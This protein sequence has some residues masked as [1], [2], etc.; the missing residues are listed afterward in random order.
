MFK[1][2]TEKSLTVS[3]EFI[4]NKCDEVFVTNSDLR[5]HVSA[6][7][8]VFKCKICEEKF[9]ICF[10]LEQHLKVHNKEKP[11]KCKKCGK[12]FHL[13]WRLRKHLQIH[14][15]DKIRYCHYPV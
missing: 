4:C 1:S 14:N 13:E 8:E 10:Q 5:T 11:N 15:N 12:T 9:S 3:K 7:H 2:I 6:K